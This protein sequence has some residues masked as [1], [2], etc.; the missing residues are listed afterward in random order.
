MECTANSEPSAMR[1]R[2]GLK[3]IEH[4]HFWHQIADSAD[5]IIPSRCR[6]NRSGQST[7]E[8][9]RTTAFHQHGR[10]V[11]NRKQL[12]LRDFNRNRQVAKTGSGPGSL[13][14][15]LF[16]SLLFS[17]LVFHELLNRVESGGSDR[18]RIDYRRTK[19]S[20]ERARA[21]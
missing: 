5:R 18:C 13:P 2:F 15:I 12:F 11:F 17:I 10:N 20:G 21:L 3:A 7:L 8:P 6:R 16:V 14:G 19:N 9:F 1:D 4:G